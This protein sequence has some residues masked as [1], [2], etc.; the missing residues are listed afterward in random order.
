[1]TINLYNHQKI[2]L[3]YTR[4]HDNFALF[5]EQGTGK[6]L[7]ALFRLR[8]LIKSKEV[9]SILVVGPKSALGAW[10]RDMELFGD[11]DTRLL[12]KHIT[13]INYDKVWRGT[14]YNNI[15][16]CIILDEAHF[17][18][19]RTSK[20][21][22][23]L[24]KL[25]SRA[26]YKYIL[27]GTP[28]SNGHLED[29]WSQFCFLD[30]YVERG[31]TYSN[32]FRRKMDEY[33]PSVKHKGSYREFLKRYAI[34]NK[35]FKPS[36]YI[37]VNEL[38]DIMDEYS[39][40]VKKDECLDLPDKLPDEIIKVDLKVKDKYKRLAT[41][42]ALLE[43][44]ILAENPL[45]RQIKLR[46]LASGFIVMEDGSIEEVPCEKISILQEIIES[47][48]SEKK[49]VIFAHF[50][51]SIANIS[52]LLTKL[53]VK[54][55]VLNGEQKDKKIWR[56]FQE[57]ESIKIIVC[58]YETASAGIDLFASDTIIYYEPTIRT[59]SLEQS[60]DR[61]HR[62]GQTQ[63]CSYIH[64]LTKGTIEVDIYRALSQY[65][66][67]T[68]ELFNEYIESYQRKYGGGKK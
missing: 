46:Q 64:L 31:H 11:E 23:F 57:D 2:A 54:Y 8:D 5:M 58:Q 14:R 37:H 43:Y 59:I 16:D 51:Q 18:K 41:K 3:S 27:T 60:R 20:R 48:P 32:I 33:E 44:D 53:K 17:I 56:K 62:T 10:E 38:Q 67:F 61:I 50:I 47:F 22:D 40:R 9:N 42:S 28:V 12:Q 26:K 52:K 63:K 55:V 19:N 1:M 7:S 29:I 34:L 36:S 68:E 49:L 6:T 35:Y 30:C 21:S 13:L 4:L 45:A 15:Y 25:A 24:L 39:F 65:A 66:D